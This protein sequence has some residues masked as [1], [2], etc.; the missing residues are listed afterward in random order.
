MLNNNKSLQLNREER[1]RQERLAR[2]ERT[3]TKVVVC[4]HNDDFVPLMQM[5]LTPP[6]IESRQVSLELEDGRWVKGLEMHFTHCNYKVATRIAFSFVDFIKSNSNI[7]AAAKEITNIDS[8][9]D[10][11]DMILINIGNIDYNLF[12]KMI[13]EFLFKTL[14]FEFIGFENKRRC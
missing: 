6:R 10:S 7:I 2:K 13:D 14:D 1:R 8:S 12:E 4:N 9:K 5:D 11:F 3:R